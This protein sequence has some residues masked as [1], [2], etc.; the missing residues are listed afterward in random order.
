MTPDN[1][2][3]YRRKLL[4]KLSQSTR[5]SK[6]KAFIADVELLFEWYGKVDNTLS[7]IKQSVIIAY[8]SP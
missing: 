1:K 2:N 7:I 4:K 3:Q 5:P 6:A 8:A